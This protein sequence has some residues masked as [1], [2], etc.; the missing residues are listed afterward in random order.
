MCGLLCLVPAMGFSRLT[1]VVCVTTGVFGGVKQPGT[2]S[3]FITGGRGSGGIVRGCGRGRG[4]PD[5][6]G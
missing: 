4:F 5:G 1:R 6:G 2:Q 3:C